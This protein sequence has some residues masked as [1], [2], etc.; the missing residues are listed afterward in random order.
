MNAG[1]V[2]APLVG[3]KRHLRAEVSAGEGTYLFA[4]NGVTVLK[5]ANV[6]A[7]AALLD[8]TRDIATLLGA[9]P[10]GMTPQQVAGLIRRLADAGL[11]ALRP[12]VDHSVDEH[13]LAYWEAIGV[14]STTAVANTSAQTLRVMTVGD[15]DVQPALAAVRAAG[16]TVAAE[17]DPCS[18]PA[19]SVVLCDDYLNPEL[20]EIDAMHRAQGLPW[21]LAKPVGVKVWLGPVFQPA[22]PGCWHCLSVRLWGHRNAEAVA[23]STLGR[24]GPAQ[25]P[26]ASIPALRAAAMGMIALEA[27]KWLSGHR[28]PNQGQ[29][30]TFDSVELRGEPHEL[31]PFPQCPTCGDPDLMRRKARRPVALESR[32]KAS[33][34][35]GHRSQTPEQVLDRY[36][37]LVSPVTGV[38]KEIRRDEHGPE[39]FNSFRSGPNVAARMNN[40]STLRATMRIEN[41][42]KGVTA[43]HA[44]ASAL[45][46]AIERYSGNFFGDEL[47]VRG[48]LRSLGDDAV[49]PNACQ[50]YDARQYES[51]SDWNAAHGP[52]QHVSAPFDE[53]VV[54]DWT[55]VWSLSERRHKLLPT[56]M[57]YFGA[58]NE[59]GPHYLHADSNGNAAGSSV[60]D[61]VLQG[62]LE[63]IEREAVALWWYNRT[64]QPAVDLERFDD[65]WLEEL[66]DVYAGLGRE[67]WVLDLTSDFGVPVMA[68]VSRRVDRENE[69]ILFGFGAHLDPRL[70]L[71]RALTEL[72]QMM[73]QL[74]AAEPDGRY[75]CEDPDMVNWLRTAT[76]AEQPYLAPDADGPALG[77]E[78]YD[79]T[80]RSD[81]LEDL[82]GLRA[83]VEE[84]GMELLVLDQ[85]RPDVELPVVKVIVPGMRHFWAR[86][87]PG[88]LFDVPVRLARLAQPTPYNQVNPIP[89]FL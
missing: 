18:A 69:E 28:H 20:A 39:F 16:L 70:A 54:M 17:H 57:L 22:E 3:F 29:I 2:A 80:P 73:P 35:G 68:A 62:L 67:V 85:T 38:I 78:D 74:I 37:H 53:D 50:L 24:R 77:P 49:H 9:M 66:R 33:Y 15:V 63:L 14:D 6:E 60:E 8:G 5:G 81:L 76:L 75:R 55:P 32:R 19:L 84:L 56:A 89:M 4:E 42:G 13:T 72:N 41:G 51:R 87:A 25:S 34:S 46:E 86:F 21:L 11:V 88:R 43:V 26:V 27:T 45:C 61:A 83:K 82:D 47:R 12:P 48:S 36:Q 30:W 58:P 79:Y 59:P 10:G 44:R 52:F 23:Q 65:P 7:L 1:T 71:R 31:R 64:T 40:V